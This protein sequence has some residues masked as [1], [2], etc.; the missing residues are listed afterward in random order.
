MEQFHKVKRDREVSRLNISYF[1]AHNKQIGIFLVH[2]PS[3]VFIILI[4]MHPCWWNFHLHH[5]SASFWIFP[6]WPNMS[7]RACTNLLGG[8]MGPPCLP[9]FGQSLEMFIRIIGQNDVLTQSIF[10]NIFDCL[11]IKGRSAI[12]TAV[13]IEDGF[14]VS[15]KKWSE[16]KWLISKRSTGRV[17]RTRGIGSMSQKKVEN[18]NFGGRKIYENRKS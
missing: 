15:Y 4:G 11:H 5:F 10:R 9:C 1:H 14:E 2:P 3:S 17:K 6:S 12:T 16:N 18:R 8:C 13:V 7:K